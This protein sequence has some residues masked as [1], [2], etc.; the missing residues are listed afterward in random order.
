MGCEICGRSS[1]TKSFHSL[2]AQERHDQA[3]ELS[4]TGSFDLAVE[5]LDLRD[6]V[7]K[8]EESLNKAVSDGEDG[9]CKAFKQAQEETAKRCAEVCE[10]QVTADHLKIVGK[11]FANAIRKELGLDE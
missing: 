6:M 5:I 8:L 3:V 10:E 1:C 9:I 2:E 7:N 4:S 11:A